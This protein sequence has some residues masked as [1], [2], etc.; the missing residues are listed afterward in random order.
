MKIKNVYHSEVVNQLVPFEVNTY[1][2]LQNRHEKKYNDLFECHRIHFNSL[3]II[4]KGKGLHTIDCKEIELQAGTI[5]PL[6]TKQVHFFHHNA[7]IEGYIITFT[8]GFITQNTS[9]QNLMHFLQLYHSSQLQIVSHHVPLLIPFIELLIREQESNNT[10]LK[11]DFIKS[12]FFALVIQ[13]KRL[14]PME[15]YNTTNERFKIFTDFK[16]LVSEEY[17][18][19]HNAKDY[20]KKIGVSYKYL[21]EITKELSGK[22]TK[23]YIDSWVLLESQRYI[24]EEKYTIKE[25]AFKMG[26]GEPTNFV[27][28]FKNKTGLTPNKFL[29]GL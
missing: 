1:K 15:H 24:A 19:T 9:E 12:I 27:R 20:A 25:I 18:S 28:F 5:V 14:A 7:T 6:I 4:T 8:D 21:N 13:I 10:Y 26:F 23:S 11:H 17:L 29:A 3:F 16:K 2:S 22:T